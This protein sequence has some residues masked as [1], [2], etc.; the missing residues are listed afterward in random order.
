MGY[1]YDVLIIGG[2]VIG[3]SIASELSRYELNVTML[4]KES[5][6]CGGASKANSG[7]IHS[8][9]Y[10]QPGS[11]KAKLCVKG[12]E[13]FKAFCEELGVEFQR[14]GKLVVARNEKEIEEL[15][16]LKDTG[17][18][19]GVYGLEFV[20]KNELKQ[21]EPNI[22][23][24]KALIV[25][26]AGIVSPY[27]LTIA[28]A[29]NAW[30]NN[31]KIN[32]NSKVL[33]ISKKKNSFEVKTAHNTF[34]TKWVINC[35]GLYCDEIA[36]MVGIKK[37][38]VYPCRGEYL[39][40]DKNFKHLINHLIYPPPQNGSGGLGIHL[41]PTFEGNILIGP[42]AEYI[43]DKED[44]RTTK[45]G[46]DRLLSDAASIL[47]N[48]PKDAYIQSY[49]GI[50][51]KLVPKD[52]KMPEDFIIEE[53]EKI[54]GFINLMGIES[55]GL[56]AAP[57]IAKMVVDIIQKTEP[58][59]LKKDFKVRRARKRFDKMSW[60]EKAKLIEKNPKHGHV[61]CRCEKVTKQEI[62]DALD[63]PLEVRT[64]SGI[65]YRSR[66]TMGR[67]QGGFCKSRII[68]IM[69]E[70][71]NPNTEDITLRGKRSSLFMG[72]TKDLRKH[73]KKES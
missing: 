48:L 37:Y 30:E 17:D 33:Q 14:T 47:K 59:S 45:A 35:A 61:I 65:K 73:D 38:K 21:L 22:E 58:L 42:S 20:N 4:E 6:V 3:C 63:N 55:P 67:C 5:D 34:Y 25:P 36:G 51:C 56:S 66:A 62:I 10:S 53:D 40:L 19:N 1:E 41:T 24:K 28:L 8:G 46:M 64:L 13:L 31:V 16:K 43:E 60:K 71:Y 54:K 50:R 32:L 44:T 29:E 12:N 23:V 2:G 57:T 68:K 27:E 72:N 26:S 18:K 9:I 52:S 15:E 69:E 70:L 49:A 11:L 39:I 7:V